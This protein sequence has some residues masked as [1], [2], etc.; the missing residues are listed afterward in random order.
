MST[1]Q[2]VGHRGRPATFAVRRAS[3]LRAATDIINHRGVG[4]VTMAEVA[5]ALDLVPTAVSY[6]FR[7]K[8]DLAAACFLNAIDTFTGLVETA[9][10]GGSPEHRLGRFLELYAGLRQAID[11]GHADPVAYF[12]DVRAVENAAVNAAYTAFFRRVRAVFIDPVLGT[13]ARLERNS[14]THLL[15]TQLYWAEAW[16]RR[17]DPSDYVRMGQTAAEILIQ[18]LAA[19]RT[20]RL[21]PLA[22]TPPRE[23]VDRAPREAFLRVATELINEKGFKGASVKE[24]SARLNVT[25]G[26]FY[27]YNQLKGDL[28]QPCFERTLGVL[29]S[30]QLAARG[31]ARNGLELVSAFA[32]ALVGSSVSG[33]APLLRTSAL[34][35]LPGGLQADLLKRY[36]RIS[37]GLSADITDGMRDGSIRVVE[38]SVAADLVIS[39][40][41]A[42]TELT[43]WAPGITP[44]EALEAYVQPLFTGLY[45]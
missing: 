9:A 34:S 22:P 2:A 45:S 13:R 5:G 10:E 38:A 8:E 24:I 29:R 25:R 15:V 1:R 14:R 40:V 26:A 7:R 33:D 35:S 20:A 41:N 27:H 11:T 3:I 19:D 36:R 16:L 31:S 43:S 12:N 18:G 37:A 17:Y 44:A 42:S 23:E 28:V 30:E 6:Y 39:L 32:G 4:A 21:A